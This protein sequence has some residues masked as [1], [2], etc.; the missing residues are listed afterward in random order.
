MWSLA[1]RQRHGTAQNL[2]TCITD[3]LPREGGTQCAAG[4]A[5][6]AHMQQGV[7]GKASGFRGWA[8]QPTLGWNMSWSYISTRR[9]CVLGSCSRRTKGFKV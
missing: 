9:N 2:S 7:R 4:A 1:V 3:T 5:A 6:Q 8:G